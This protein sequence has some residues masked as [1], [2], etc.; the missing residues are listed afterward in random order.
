MR[1]ILTAL[2]ALVISACSVSIALP[3]TST[4][5]E[6]VDLLIRDVSVVDVETGLIARDQ[7]V[8]IRGDTIFAVVADNQADRFQAERTIDADDRYLMP[9][10]WDMHIHFG[11]EGLEAD[12]IALF[13]LYVANGV[14]AV[15]DAAGDLSAQVLDWRANPPTPV[16]PRVFTSGPKIEGIAPVWKGVIETGSQVDV[17]A[18]LD[19][20]QALDVDFVKITDNTLDPQLFLYVVRQAKARGMRTSAHI[21]MSL[22]VLEAAEAGLS[23]IEHLGY[24]VKAGSPQEAEIA[25]DYAAGQL[26]YAQAMARYADTFDEATARRTYARL[27]EL[28]VAVTPT[29][30]GGQVIAWL[31]RDDHSHDPELAYIGDGLRATYDWRVQRA[32]QATPEQVEARHRVEAVTARTLPLLRD[33][34]VVLLA[35]TDAGYL[36]SYNY[37]GFSIHSELEAYV[38]AG[39]TPREALAAS[40]VNGPRWLGQGDRYVAVAQGRAADLILLDDNPLQDVSATRHPALVVIRGRPLDRPAL[41]ALLVEIAGGVRLRRQSAEP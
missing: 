13:P 18:A 24:L 38:A 9:G 21:P 20:L 12:N 32:A 8:A 33:A 34:G 22:T 14:V 29:L 4:P 10:L 39:L 28:G 26:T 23:S 11:G 17:D 37:P 2:S 27:A 41:D 16:G 25:A 30:H 15:R 1:P 7:A 19:R 40:V 35:G 36:N 6:P 5:A 31:D 3:E